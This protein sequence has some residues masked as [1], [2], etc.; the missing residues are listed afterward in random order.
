MR[1]MI[2]RDRYKIP[3]LLELNE[4]KGY[5]YIILSQGTHPTAYVRV[6]KDSIF[7]GRGDWNDSL[8]N[9]PVD[10]IPCHWGVTYAND[11]LHWTHAGYDC[12]YEKN[13]GYWFIGWDYAHCDD[14]TYSPINIMGID[15]GEKWTTEKIVNECHK[16]IDA[17]IDIEAKYKIK[18]AFYDWAWDNCL[19]QSYDCTKHE[20][21]WCDLYDTSCICDEE[22]DCYKEFCQEEGIPN[23]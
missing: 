10:D 6:D 8:K 21:V 18:S 3:Q 13:N 19:C 12:N 20:Y 16:V 5:T 9:N 1:E 17:M 22:R 7:Y 4:Y 23:E 14:Y 15:T 2:Y 11:H